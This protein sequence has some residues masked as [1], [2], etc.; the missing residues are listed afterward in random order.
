MEIQSDKEYHR[1]ALALLVCFFI[2]FMYVENVLRP[3]YQG[4][5]PQ[6]SGAASQGSSGTTAQGTSGER[7]FSSSHSS[8][9][10][11]R[12]SGQWC[13]SA[14]RAHS[15]HPAADSCGTGKSKPRHGCCAANWR[16][17]GLASYHRRNGGGKDQN[18]SGHCFASWRAHLRASFVG[19]QGFAG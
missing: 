18:S 11:S 1:K 12:D 14:S 6:S 5:Q 19:L 17:S 16:P 7:S 9:C 10:R 2:A 4:Q 13:C 3:Y 15:D 8:R